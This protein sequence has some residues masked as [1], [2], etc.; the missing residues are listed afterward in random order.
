MVILLVLQYIVLI[1][2]HYCVYLEGLPILL[3]SGT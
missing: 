1:S 2:K 3:I